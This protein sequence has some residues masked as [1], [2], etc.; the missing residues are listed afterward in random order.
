VFAP[1]HPWFPVFAQ[2]DL[3]DAVIT[4]KDGG[5]QT[6]IVK[7]GEGTVSYTE[8]QVVEYTLDKGSLDEVRLG[9]ESPLEV[10]MGFTWQ[11]IQ[12]FSTGAAPTIEETI[13]GTGQASAW[14]STDAD[15]CRPYAVDI[16]IDLNPTCS[17]SHQ[18]ITLPDFRWEQMDHDVRA[19]TVQLTGK[20]NVLVPTVVHA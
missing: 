15:T 9:D 5:S 3:K 8:R 20:C 19:G 12:N 6:A 18:T 13:K 1:R 10:T 7:V 16:E 4:I 17:A 14:V 11:Y 2:V